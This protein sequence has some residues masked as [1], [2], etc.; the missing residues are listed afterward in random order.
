VDA[1]V[2]G[3]GETVLGAND[4][5]GGA[6]RIDGADVLAFFLKSFLDVGRDGFNFEFV[7]F[8]LLVQA[9]FGQGLFE[10][11][12]VIEKIDQV[13]D[14]L[15]DDSRTARGTEREDRA[16]SAQDDGGTHTGKGTFAGSDRV[17]FCADQAEEVRRAWLSRKVIHLIVHDDTGAGNDDFGTE[18]GVDGGGA[19][20]PVPTIVRGGE[21]RGMFAE[22]RIAE[23][24][25]GAVFRNGRGVVERDSAGQGLG[26]FG[27]EETARDVDKIG[28]AQPVSP[29]SKSKF[30][31]F[32][33]EVN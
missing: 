33:D 10:V 7:G 26:I 28:I 8:P 15:A 12:S 32:G 3:G 22:E 11:H 2:G 14:G 24:I 5:L 18:S 20:D 25:G 29:I 6:H 16:A 27:G 21:M 23:L 19:G 1:G 31:G 17:G 13:Y 4:N 30:H 9:W